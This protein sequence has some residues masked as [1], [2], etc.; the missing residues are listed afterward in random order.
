MLSV[1]LEKVWYVFIPLRMLWSQQQKNHKL[2]RLSCYIS[3]LNN[4]PIISK[5]YFF[6][7]NFKISISRRQS[8]LLDSPIFSQPSMSP[9]SWPQ[10]D[11]NI[12]VTMLQSEVWWR[13][14]TPRARNSRDC[15]VVLRTQLAV[16][17]GSRVWSVDRG[18]D[19]VVRRY[20]LEP[21]QPAQRGGF[22]W[23]SHIDEILGQSHGLAVATDGDGPVKVGGS[24][25]VLAVGDANHCSTYLPNLC[26]LGSPLSDHA[27]NNFVGYRHLM[28]LV[29]IRSSTSSGQSCRVEN[30]GSKSS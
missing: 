1:L 17:R 20:V 7:F 22:H 23:Y 16:R 12:C 18:L 28:G 9:S 3:V 21:C 10:E 30:S 29:C 11:W 15:R 13:V 5:L 27:A 25:P 8:D 19:D 4:I 24:I 2:T 26:N 6:K 14:T